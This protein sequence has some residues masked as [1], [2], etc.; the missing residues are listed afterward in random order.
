[1]EHWPNVNEKR[2]SLQSDQIAPVASHLAGGVGNLV[3]VILRSEIYVTSV[4]S[5]PAITLFS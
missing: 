4:A 5:A 1:M 2:C 3:G